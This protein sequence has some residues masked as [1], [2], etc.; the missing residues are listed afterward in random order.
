MYISVRV[1]LVNS[2]TNNEIKVLKEGLSLEPIT[3]ELPL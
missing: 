1:I 2:W 3:G